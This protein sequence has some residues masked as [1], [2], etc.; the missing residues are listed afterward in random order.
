MLV[1]P[2][3][4]TLQTSPPFFFTFSLTSSV[5]F[6]DVLSLRVDAIDT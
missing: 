3:S 4:G 6:S 1:R 5:F 2:G